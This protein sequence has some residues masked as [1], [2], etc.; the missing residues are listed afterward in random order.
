M[1]VILV[2]AFRL[3]T[4]AGICSGP[5]A[6]EVHP[7]YRTWVERALAPLSDAAQREG[8]DPNELLELAI[9]AACAAGV[10]LAE[11][12]NAGGEHDVLLEVD[13]D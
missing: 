5:T 1:W 3:A 8:T 10:L 13:A 4:T 6:D 12:F 9:E 7:E 11:R 2:S